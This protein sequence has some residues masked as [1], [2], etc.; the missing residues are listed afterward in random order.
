MSLLTGRELARE[1]RATTAGRAAELSERGVVPGLAIIVPTDDEATAWYVRSLVA[2]ADKVG[3]RCEVVDVPASSGEAGTTTIVAALRA[4]CATPEVHGVICQTPLPEGVALAEVGAAIDPERD[5]DGANPASLGALMTGISPVGR[6]APATATAIL[7]LLDHAGVELAGKRAVV[8]GR[9]AVV[10]QPTAALLLAR[11][12]TVTICHSRTVDLHEHTR[13]ADVLVVAAGRPGL[14]GA[15]HVKP[16]AVVIDAGTTQTDD[17]RLLGDVDT[18]A[19]AAHATVTP[20]PGG[21]GPVTT[22][23]LLRHVV[24]AAARANQ[25]QHATRG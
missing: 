20:V 2:A 8:I 18:D 15:D 10:G 13:S 12:A 3:V 21:V 4:A 25:P 1:T 6:F 7:A 19:V 24:L 14:I 5:V 11:D 23:T 17:G 9:S 16:G 22:A